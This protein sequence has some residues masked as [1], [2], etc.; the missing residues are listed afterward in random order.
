MPKRQVTEGWW[1]ALIYGGGGYGFV[2]ID[3]GF[4][5]LFPVLRQA[6]PSL[7]LSTLLHQLPGRW[8]YRHVPPS[9]H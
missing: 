7:E 8:N 9:L 1:H 2:T 3:A 5:I 6:Q 4:F